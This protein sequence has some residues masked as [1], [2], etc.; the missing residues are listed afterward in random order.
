MSL[1]ILQSHCTDSA[2]VNVIY[3]GLDLG[4]VTA[5]HCVEIDDLFLDF[6]REYSKRFCDFILRVIFFRGYNMT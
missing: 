4:S 1:L 5:V 3:T 2:G 6:E